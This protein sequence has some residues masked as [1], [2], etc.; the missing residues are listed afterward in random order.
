[1]LI[2]YRLEPCFD[3]VTK[4]DRVRDLHHGGFHVQREQ[5]AFGLR[6]F[7]LVLKERRKRLGR[8]EGSVNNRARGVRDTLFQ[9]GLGA[10]SGGQHDF[11]RR[12]SRQRGGF[13][14]GAEIIARHRGDAGLAVGHP[15]THPVR[16]RLSKVLH[17]LGGTTVRVAFAQDRVHRRAFDAIVPGAD[18]F[19]GVSLRLFGVIRQCIALRLKLFD[20]R[21][22]LRH[23]RR[24]IGQLNHVGLGRFDQLAQFGQIIGLTLIF[25]QEIGEGRDDPTGQRDILG[26]DGH[27]R[28]TGKPL[29]DRQQRRRGQLRRFVDLGVDNIGLLCV[30]GIRPLMIFGMQ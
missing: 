26:A 30:H 10:I 2:K 8:H 16:V 15:F 13:L 17:G 28:R 18:V 6:L 11:G 22:Q 29:N 14:V 23:G 4:D 9:N 1:M 24:N 20:R 27:A 21:H 25:G 19:L 12:I 5:R 3:R 7:D